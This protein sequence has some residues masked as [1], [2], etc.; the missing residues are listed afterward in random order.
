MKTRD[1]GVRTK[2]V[3]CVLAGS[4][5]FLNGGGTSLVSIA[6]AQKPNGPAAAPPKPPA[7]AKPNLNEAKKRYGAGEKKY[8]DKDYA[9]ALVEFQ[10]ADAIIREPG[11]VRLLVAALKTGDVQPWTLGFRHR[12][13]L[14]MNADPEIR[15]AA[16]PILSQSPADREAVDPEG[17]TPERIDHQVHRRGMCRV[18]GAS[19][20]AACPANERRR[21]AGEQRSGRD[22]I[23]SSG[24]SA[25]ASATGLSG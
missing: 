14:M 1:F 18:L 3:A 9:G 8:N 7:D 10:A 23:I 2:L 22:T 17:E 15:E 5:A 19:M 4:M 16:R 6:Y 24:P 11:R 20:R 21:P 25:S 13:R 12:N